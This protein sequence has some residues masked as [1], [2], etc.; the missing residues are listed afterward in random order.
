MPLLYLLINF[1]YYSLIIYDYF[2]TALCLSLG[3]QSGSLGTTNLVRLSASSS[4]S[5]LLH[6]ITQKH[7]TYMN[8]R[9]AL[10]HL[11]FSP[12]VTNALPP[13]SG[14]TLSRHHHWSKDHCFLIVWKE[15]TATIVLR[16]AFQRWVHQTPQR[17]EGLNH[18]QLHWIHYEELALV[19][20]LEDR[21][22]HQRQFHSKPH[23][24]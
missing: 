17:M 6:R 22:A 10:A 9:G 12:V 15:S 1:M 16:E 5:R 24:H 11:S 20:S 13:P 2:K 8:E 18:R 21:A 7:H 3:F 4:N 14:T 23:F 19:L